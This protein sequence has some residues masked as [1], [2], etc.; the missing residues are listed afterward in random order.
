M[1]E[2]TQCCHCALSVHHLPLPQR[3]R[4]FWGANRAT[5]SSHVE[6]HDGV[7]TGRRLGAVAVCV[8]VL[9]ACSSGDDGPESTAR[10]V[11]TSTD[12]APTPTTVTTVAQTTTG[13]SIPPSTTVGTTS[14]TSST[15]T[16]VDPATAEADVRV[17][18]SRAIDDFSECLLALPN[19][20][21][22]MLAATRAN[23]MLAVNASRVSEW[24][25]AGYTVIDRDQ[26]R[27]VV[28]AV[29]LADDL[30]RATAT[31][32]FAD[33]SKLIHAGAAPGGADLVIDGTFSS[34][35]E[36]WDMRLDDDGVWRAYDAPLI[37]VTEGTDVCPPE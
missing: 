8:L 26:L 7:G 24:N 13:P 11:P 9:V 14:S 25:A 6:R 5:R 10:S 3:A 32:C 17:A 20:D 12:Q 37:G 27:Y 31:V 1:C 21:V 33:G 29:E 19:C 28:E 36:A 2:R 30:R 22:T 34:G 4:P 15:S 16:T 18:V 35:R 23:P